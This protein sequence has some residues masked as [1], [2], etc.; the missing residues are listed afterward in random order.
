[1]DPMLARA[2]QFYRNQYDYPWAVLKIAAS[3]PIS[4]G[5][6]VFIQFYDQAPKRTDLSLD[7]HQ[8]ALLAPHL[9]HCLIGCAS[10]IYW[11]FRTF[12]QSDKYARQRVQKFFHHATNT[13]SAAVLALGQAQAH[14][15]S[16]RWGDA[17]SSVGSLK[18]L[19]Q[20]PF[21]SKVIAFL[22]LE[23]AGVYDNRINRF[24]LQSGL[25]KPMIGCPALP[26]KSGG[27]M[28]YPKVAAQNSQGV[29]QRW[30]ERLQELRDQLNAIGPGCQWQCTESTPQRWRA[31]DVERAIFQLAKALPPPV[32]IAV[33]RTERAV[34]R[35]QGLDETTPWRD[36][37][38][39]PGANDVMRRLR[40]H[41]ESHPS[42]CMD[43]AV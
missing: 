30:C 1:M 17:V 38:E 35:P 12:G 21:A 27:N 24:L 31:V 2:F 26:V 25:D 9:A 4:V 16:H 23:N 13:M 34:A 8:S 40:E 43:F 42:N 18:E 6:G 19:G 11:G 37:T 36:A 10:A 14:C 33:R 32:K 41:C 3:G 22:D 39:D 15:S 20:L 28:S 7:N 5:A 29:F